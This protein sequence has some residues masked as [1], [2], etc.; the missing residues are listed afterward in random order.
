MWQMS[1]WACTISSSCPCALLSNPQM[2][3]QLRNNRCTRHLDRS[4]P[5]TRRSGGR[6]SCCRSWTG[7][8]LGQ[9]NAAAKEGCGHPE[10]LDDVIAWD[11][12]LPEYLQQLAGVACP[13]V[14]PGASGSLAYTCQPFQILSW[15]PR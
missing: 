10:S 6:P 2:A 3:W 14:Q 13:P 12:P 7:L 15:H 4:G 8:P 11:G 1:S 5:C 9:K